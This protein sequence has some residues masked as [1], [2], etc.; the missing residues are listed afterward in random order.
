[1]ADNRNSY[2]NT[3]TKFFDDIRKC[4]EQT[5]SCTCHN[6]SCIYI[7]TLDERLKKYR[8][9]KQKENY[10]LRRNIIS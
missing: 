2:L 5:P 3:L 1:M 8:E 9:M 4:P 10:L 6:G 7:G